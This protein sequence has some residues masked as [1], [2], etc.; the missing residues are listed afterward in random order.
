MGILL[1]SIIGLFGS[2]FIEHLTQV[3]ISDAELYRFCMV[4]DIKLND[5]KMP[6]FPLEVSDGK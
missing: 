4:H 3:N 6:E 1:G 5:C 2:L